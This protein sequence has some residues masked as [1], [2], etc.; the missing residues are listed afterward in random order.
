MQG[1]LLDRETSPYLLQHRDNPVHWRPWGDAALAEARRDNK[2]IL[3]SVGYAACHWC[4]VMAHESFENPEIAALMN[5]RFVNVKVDRE[6]R[7][8]IDAIY[9]LALQLLGQQGGWP[10]TMFLTPGGEPFWGGTY[11]PPRPQWGRPGFGEILTAIGDTYANEPEKVE[12]NVTA[13]MQ[14]LE[15][16]SAPRGEGPLP[17]MSDIDNHAEQLLGH[18]DFTY[19]GLGGAPKF[20]QPSALKALWQGALR[21]GNKRM[22]KAVTLSLECISEG[23]IYDHLGGGF[24]RYSVDEKWLVPHFEKM[25]YDNAELMDLMTLV[26]QHS[27]SP[28]LAERVAETADW[29]MEEMCQ[30]GGGFA[31][32]LD[33]DSEGEEGLYY[34]WGQEEVEA[35]LTPPEAELFIRIYD[36]TPGGNWEGRTI[37]NRLSWDPEELTPEE[38][39][40]LA[41]ARAKL[42]T[43]REA[44]IPPGKDDKIL[45]DWNGLM[46]AALARAGEAFGRADWIEAAEDGFGFVTNDMSAG[47][48]RLHHSYREGEA[49]HRAVLDDYANMAQAGLVLAELTGN[50]DRYLPP[51]RRW[52]EILDSDYRDPEGGG[53]FFTATQADDLITRTKNGSDNAVPSG[54]GT[55]VGVF[56]RAYLMTGETLYRIR[57][58]EITRA[59]AGEAQMNPYPMS[60]FFNNLE[61]ALTPL[62]VVLAGTTPG[63]TAAL[64]RVV[65]GCSLPTLVLGE[66]SAGMELPEGHPAQGK[67]AVDG[68][69]AAYVCQGPVCSAPITDPAALKEHLISID[70]RPT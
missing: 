52:L 36:V 58:E 46:I 69:P 33:A 67:T 28:L 45:A 6:E 68:Q 25:L 14:G 32:S 44:R 70:K 47:E 11:F 20:P 65:A 60:T 17:V 57:A 16:F 40:L 63:D 59:L 43:A 7:P 55:L 37:L 66:V 29:L 31:S 2:P 27:R 19:G 41:S 30:P 21:T 15:R 62:Q 18:V 53:Y 12:K 61:L 5:A 10:L 38:Q 56:T 35:L 23:G 26:W 3:L 54:N 48:G 13:L 22:E 50:Q 24:A 64:R 42:L 9:Q 1:N 39:A 49:R 34:I 51:V 8:D 4:H